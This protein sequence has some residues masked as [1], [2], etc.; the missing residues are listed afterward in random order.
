MDK[1][2]KLI[3]TVYVTALRTSKIN[4]FNDHMEDLGRQNTHTE[5][6]KSV[7][8]ILGVCYNRDKNRTAP[9]IRTPNMMETSVDDKGVSQN[10]TLSK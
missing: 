3:S 1:T 5:C 4:S 10:P 9:V 7:H 8:K 2:I 6:G